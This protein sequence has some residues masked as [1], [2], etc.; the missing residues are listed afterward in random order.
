MKLSPT[1]LCLRRTW[2]GPG[3]PT[4]ASCHSSTSG[5][6]VFAKRIACTMGL[7]LLSCRVVLA[8]RAFE[9][10]Q[11]LLGC[12]PAGAA[13]AAEAALRQYPV[14]GDDD[15]DRVP[16]AGAADGAGRRADE[17]CELAIGAGLAKRD[18]AH[19]RPNA[20]LE[21]RSRRIERQVEAV[22]RSGEIS[23]QLALGLG[24][25]RAAVAGRRVGPTDRD[26]RV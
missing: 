11:R 8:E 3:L 18:P 19:R 17:G 24:E 15:R 9:R 12:H 21:R 5:P 6:P 13:I 10:E 22:E 16:A 25:E 14:A 1:A 23:A 4:S 20:L 2:P 26:D 7:A